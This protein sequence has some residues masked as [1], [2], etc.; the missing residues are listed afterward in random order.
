MALKVLVQCRVLCDMVPDM[1][2]TL[3]V[4]HDPIDWLM[5]NTIC[6]HP[7]CA[8]SCVWCCNVPQLV[9]LQCLTPGDKRTHDTCCTREH[10]DH[11]LTPNLLL[12]T[13]AIF[14]QIPMRRDSTTAGFPVVLGFQRQYIRILS[15]LSSYLQ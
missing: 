4:F 8:L 9:P 12:N 1:Y 11:H 15:S 5:N 7:I 13:Y 10:V 14:V 3:L 2:H 6:K